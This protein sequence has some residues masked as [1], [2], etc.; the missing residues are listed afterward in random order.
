[1]TDTGA[2]LPDDNSVLQ[3]VAVC[4]SVLQCVEVCCR[5]GHPILWIPDTGANLPV[6][7]MTACCSLLQR[8]A[9]YLMLWLIL[10]QIFTL[11]TRQ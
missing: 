1:M 2:S 5:A 4:C 11:M 10:V 3:C 9:V 6:D 8:V 7:D